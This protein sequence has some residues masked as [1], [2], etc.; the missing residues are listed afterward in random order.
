LAVSWA[1]EQ[2][3]ISP[4]AVLEQ[5]PMGVTIVSGSKTMDYDAASNNVD[6]LIPGYQPTYVYDARRLPWPFKDKEFELLVSLRVLQHLVPK[7]REC[8]LEAKRVSR[9]MILVIPTKS[10]HPRGIDRE[11]L[12][13]WNSGV[14]PTKEHHY[15]G[16]LG[17]A[18]LFKW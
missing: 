17:S 13:E 5:G 7:Q 8:F 3:L 10:V 6:W 16:Q 12:V 18:Y 4:D 15:P 14:E 9:A 11:Q 2:N 1:K